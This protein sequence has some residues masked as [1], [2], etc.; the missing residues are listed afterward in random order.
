M[1]RRVILPLLLGFGF[2]AT[3]PLAFRGWIRIMQVSPDA[4]IAKIGFVVGA[5]GALAAFAHFV[6]L[7]ILAAKR[8]REKVATNFTAWPFALHMLCGYWILVPAGVC[9]TMRGEFGNDAN[10]WKQNEDQIIEVTWQVV[11]GER[12]GE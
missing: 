9:M 1:F 8:R 11:R 5:L 2:G 4:F 3:M 7:V 10:A 12:P 6:T